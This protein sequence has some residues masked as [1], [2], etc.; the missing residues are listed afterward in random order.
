IITT[1]ICST[2]QPMTGIVSK[3][4]KLTKIFAECTFKRSKIFGIKKNYSV[5]T[6]VSTRFYN[7]IFA[8]FNPFLFRFFVA[9]ASALLPAPQKIT[10]KTGGNAKH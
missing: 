10:G 8:K 5:K 9:M 6:A 1:I 3:K 2:I 4:K 7:I